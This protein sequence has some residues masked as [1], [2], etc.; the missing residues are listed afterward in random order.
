MGSHLGS[1]LSQQLSSRLK[2]KKTLNL[3]GNQDWL[4]EQLHYFSGEKVPN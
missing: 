3:K 2:G 1:D 4:Q